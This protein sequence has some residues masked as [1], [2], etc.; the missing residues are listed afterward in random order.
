MSQIVS[1]APALRCPPVLTR[2]EAMRPQGPQRDRV[3]PAGAPFA[4]ALPLAALFWGGLIWA[5]L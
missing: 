2:P 1:L 3:W 5:V 4:L